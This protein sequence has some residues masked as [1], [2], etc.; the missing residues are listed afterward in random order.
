LSGMAEFCQGS[1]THRCQAGRKYFSVDPYGYVHPCVDTPAV[2]HLLKDDVSAIRSPRALSDVHS[3]SG[4]WYCFR[5]EADC[6]LSPRGYFEKLHAAWSVVLRNTLRSLRRA[7][8]ARGVAS[9]EQ[10]GP[11]PL[12]DSCPVQEIVQPAA[13]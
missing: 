10:P 7:S 12:P 2:G 4:C 11:V 9:P 8:S 5:G 6:M 13:F 1:T 3:C